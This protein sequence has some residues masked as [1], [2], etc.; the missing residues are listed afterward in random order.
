MDTSRKDQG[1]VLDLPSIAPT[2]R[3]RPVQQPPLLHAS[4]SNLPHVG[5]EGLGQQEQAY[6]HPTFPSHYQT[7]PV[8]NYPPPPPPPA[9]P[10]RCMADNEGLD[11][12]NRL[13]TSTHARK[14]SRKNSILQRLGTVVPRRLSR[15][16]G[17]GV[18]G[19]DNGGQQDKYRRGVI[20]AEDQITVDLSGFE[21]PIALDHLSA[22][23]GGDVGES[24]KPTGTIWT[25]S[26][27]GRDGVRNSNLGAGMGTIKK[28][29][30]EAIP[31]LEGAAA[32]NDSYEALR[33]RVEI[34][35]AAESKGE[36]IMLEGMSG[37]IQ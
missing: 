3:Y 4:F 25:T 2:H 35:R 18:L 15:Q 13:N 31:S 34:Q 28:A 23:K 26:Y 29:R 8:Y 36:I 7:T 9:L 5:Q 32:L 33:A 22:G 37:F 30:I 21:G 24:G 12:H 14:S 17:Y 19:D 6:W 27:E 1:Q 16:Q 10:P 20:D 11:G